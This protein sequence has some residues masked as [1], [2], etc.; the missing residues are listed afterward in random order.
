[1]TPEEFEKCAAWKPSK[2]AL[3]GEGDWMSGGAN[4]PKLSDEFVAEARRLSQLEKKPSK[5]RMSTLESKY[6]FEIREQQDK[7]EK[8]AKRKST[9]LA[10]RAS[11]AAENP[12]SPKNL[13]R[14]DMHP[15]LPGAVPGAR[16]SVD[17]KGSRVTV[18]EGAPRERKSIHQVL[19]QNPALKADVDRVK[20]KRDTA[21]HGLN[22]TDP[23]DRAALD[24][25][26]LC[27][28]PNGDGTGSL[29]YREFSRLVKDLG[30][31]LSKGEV[32]GMM[33]QLDA[34]GNG[35]IEI[36]EFA[37]FFNHAGIR[38]DMKTDA[39]DMNKKGSK[40]L[41]VWKL[42][43]EFKDPFGRGVDLEGLKLLLIAGRLDKGP[44]K[45][46]PKEA[47]LSRKALPQAE[48]SW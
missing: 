3:P 19:M 36:D 14:P 34:N 18:A 40:N 2:E 39:K 20:F 4:P 23:N 45:V 27:Y 35:C 9:M 26:F 43:D 7:L 22:P 46:T 38:G 13:P 37:L 31:S 10:K 1:M 47:D 44:N 41:F 11:L 16:A 33:K 21:K 6:A 12:L 30:L 5:K 8:D 25:L 48:R 42:F 28:D 32:E 15:N 17:R 29:T 24:D